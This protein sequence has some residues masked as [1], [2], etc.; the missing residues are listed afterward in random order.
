MVL[1]TWRPHPDPVPPGALAHGPSRRRGPSGRG[2]PAGR[3]KRDGV[4]VLLPGASSSSRLPRPSRRSL[5]SA[6]GAVGR[7]VEGCTPV[8]EPAPRG[9]LAW[10]R[11]PGGIAASSAPSSCGPTWTPASATPC[12]CFPCSRCWGPWGWPA[13]GTPRVA[14][15]LAVAALL[16]LQAASVVT[17]YPHLLSYTS[18]WAGG[19]DRA[20]RVIVDS[21]LDWGQGLLELRRFMSEKGVSRVR[22]AYFGSAMPEAYGIDYVP[23]PSFF[24]L[25]GGRPGECAASPSSPPRC[26]RASICRGTTHTRR[27]VR[28]RPTACSAV[29]F[30]STTKSP[31]SDPKRTTRTDPPPRERARAGCPKTAGA[32]S[33]NRRGDF[34]APGV[35]SADRPCE[36]R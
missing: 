6:G 23:L 26:S 11:P 7:L 29:P 13:C 32:G 21:S 5:R 17:A 9:R 19:R 8:R 25:E 12:R 22:L 15:R 10:A 2:V 24:R 31:P 3:R 16:L 28:A 35:P 27:I 33:S 18:I 20:H 34:S 4:V 30:W 36:R 1:Y 14:V